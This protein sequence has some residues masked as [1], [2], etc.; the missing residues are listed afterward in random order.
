MNTPFT[1]EQFFS[2]FEK[3]NHTVFPAQIILLLLG[4]FAL[5]AIGLGL[6]H[7]DKFITGI[8]G[9][10]WFW[11]GIGYHLTFFSEINKVAYGFGGL[12]IIQGL[13]FLYEGL[14]KNNLRFAFQHSFQGYVAFFFILY[15]LVIYPIVG[16]L[17]EQNINHTISLGLPCPT[18]IFTFGFLLLT[19]KWFSKKLLIIPSL[20]AIIGISAVINLGIYQDSMM[21][22]T[23]IIS[24]SWLFRRKSPS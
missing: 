15:G 1:T 20:W 17:I 22:I 12:F 24:D 19:D 5:M 10:L 21:L 6:K 23:A 8:L 11:I 18:T 13:F 16:Y 9:L 14:V 3:Y 7:K 4:T 2:I